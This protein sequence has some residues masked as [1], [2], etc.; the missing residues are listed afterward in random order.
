MAAGFTL[1]D[2]DCLDHALTLSQDTAAVATQPGDILFIGAAGT[3]FFGTTVAQ[4]GATWEQIDFHTSSSGASCAAF[5][6]TGSAGSGAITITEDNNNFEDLCWS[7]VRP[8]DLGAASFAAKDNSGS[9]T[10]DTLTL[11]LSGASETVFLAYGYTPTSG[12]TWATDSGW[13]ELLDQNNASGGSHQIQYR[14]TDDAEVILDANLNVQ[15]LGWVVQFAAAAA[16]A[17]AG[18]SLINRGLINQGLINSGLINRSRLIVP[19]G[20]QLQGAL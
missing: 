11:D 17:T 20:V 5:K 19:V 15:T 8:T 2:S 6:S 12:R 13:T 3:Q 18:G 4:A 9:S 1:V 14:L 7:V 10:V 16:T